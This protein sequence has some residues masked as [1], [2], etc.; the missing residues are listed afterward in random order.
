MMTGLLIKEIIFRSLEKSTI[1]QGNKQTG[2]KETPGVN[3]RTFMH[4]RRVSFTPS[5]Y[6]SWEEN[7]YTSVTKIDML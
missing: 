4:I 6:L 1:L 3:A 2:G 7:T 5:Q